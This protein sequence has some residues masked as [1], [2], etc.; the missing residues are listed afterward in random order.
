MQ[1]PVTGLWKS[2]NGFPDVTVT[3]AFFENSEEPPI[4]FVEAEI[5]GDSIPLELCGDEWAA[6]VTENSLSPA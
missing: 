6:F 5:A 4:L 3:D 2:S 1:L